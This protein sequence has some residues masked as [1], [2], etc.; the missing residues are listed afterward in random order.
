MKTF[1]ATILRKLTSRKLWIAV[2]GVAGGIALALGAESS[3]IQ[4]ICGTVT[5][6]VSAVTYIIAE[7]SVDKASVLMSYVETNESE[8][9]VE[10]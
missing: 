10:F 8:T 5:S 4:S 1:M 9:K 2:A 3:D 7:A 6:V